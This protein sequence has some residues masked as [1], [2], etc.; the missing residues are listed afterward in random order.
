MQFDENYA[1]FRMISTDMAIG[2]SRGPSAIAELLVSVA[3]PHFW[4]HTGERL[5]GL[6]IHT[7]HFISDSN[8][9]NC[10]EV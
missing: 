2:A 6:N 10:R 5:R 9:H 1:I 3:A 7:S 8:R 4:L